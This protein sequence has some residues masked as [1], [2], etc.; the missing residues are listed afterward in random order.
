MYTIYEA[1][2]MAC[3]DSLISELVV[4][5][6][7][8]LLFEYSNIPYGFKIFKIML[9]PLER[10]ELYMTFLNDKP[11]FVNLKSLVISIEGTFHVN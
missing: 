9:L 8:S 3:V 4:V 1:E 11:V 2:E 6:K 7:E 10:L 5:W